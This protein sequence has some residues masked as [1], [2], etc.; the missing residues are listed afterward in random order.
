M[1]LLL[2]LKH[3]C[4]CINLCSQL[5]TKENGPISHSNGANVNSNCT[6]LKTPFHFALM[7]NH[8]EFVLLLLQNGAVFNA[9]DQEKRTPIEEGLMRIQMTA[10][11]TIIL[12]I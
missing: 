11:K 7:L 9:K 4:N 5:Q 2:I 10:F 1:V 3:W 8:E 6:D 12:Y